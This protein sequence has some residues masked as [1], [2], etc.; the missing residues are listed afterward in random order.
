MDNIKKLYDAIVGFTDIEVNKVHGMDYEPSDRDVGIFSATFCIGIKDINGKEY[1]LFL[2]DEQFT[3][4]LDAIKHHRN[5]NE[6]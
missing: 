3:Q 5:F 2:G 6:I 1:N 4:L